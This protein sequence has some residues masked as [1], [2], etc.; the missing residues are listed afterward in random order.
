ML[1]L[2]V[3]GP[4][5]NLPS[6]DP[7]CLAAIAYLSQAVP[8]SEWE[9]V[10]SSDPTLSPTRELPALRDDLIWIAGFQNIIAHLVEKSDG[11]WNLDRNCTSQDRADISAYTSFLSTRG[12]VLLD[13]SLYVSSE[14][15][16]TSTR[17]AYARIL[18]WP[19]TWLLPPQRHAAA[20][21]RT[22]HLNFSSLNLDTVDKDAESKSQFAAGTE[23]PTRVL[24]STRSKT[25]AGRLAKEQHA[26]RFRLDGL[27]EGL[28][29]PL[30]KLLRGN[31]YLLS[32]DRATSLD[33]LA[34]GYLSLALMPELPQPWLS[35]LL[36][37]KYP[38][39]CQY[40]ETLA[41]QSF[42]RWAMPQKPP[43]QDRDR[44]T[45]STSP[46]TP[47][48]PGSSPPTQPSSPWIP[49]NINIR[50][51]L[52][53]LP[54][55]GPL[56]RPSP[57]QTR[58]T[59]PPNH[60]ERIPLIPTLVLGLTATLAALGTHVLWTGEL[61]SLPPLGFAGWPYRRQRQLNLD[62]MGEAGALL[63][64]VDFSRG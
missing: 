30:T 13:L 34:L 48:L 41:R 32:Q 1:Q 35:Q 44:D 39:L 49:F 2:H 28:F 58:T 46:T 12:Q 56:Y 37:S 38:S 25:K 42:G 29:E 24:Q 36:R 57:L 54:L 18:P 27:A 31:D 7:Q 21:A 40:V 45:A 4:A 55:F 62:E 33:C 22:D 52:E 5:F 10:P 8:K 60:R 6:I 50:L 47:I 53:S 26:A 15:Y 11:E 63:G 16:H 3:W 9:L 19:N 59:H 17:P 23:I 20:K 64:S 14:N 51:I 43:D 61:P